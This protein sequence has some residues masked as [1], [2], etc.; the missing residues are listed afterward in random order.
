MPDIILTPTQP[1][2]T[3]KE[4]ADDARFFLSEGRHIRIRFTKKDGT[5]RVAVVTSNLSR[6]PA[7]KH[8]KYVRSVPPGYL[9][10]FDRDK[11][12]WISCHESQVIGVS[13]FI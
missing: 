6:I 7:H 3:P 13:Q 8:P 10:M 1:A 9:A 12:D 4:L 5:E 2:Y 11:G